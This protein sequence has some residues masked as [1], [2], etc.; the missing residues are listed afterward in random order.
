MRSAMA[1][2]TRTG[3]P[4]GSR[5]ASSRAAAWAEVTTSLAVA[6]TPM[7]LIW[8]AMADG[9]REALLVT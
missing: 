6:A 4:A 7:P 5:P 1:P 3:D 9:E 2:T 8:A